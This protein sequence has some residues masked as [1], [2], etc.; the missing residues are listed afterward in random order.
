MEAVTKHQLGVGVWPIASS[1]GCETREPAARPKDPFGAWRQA[2]MAIVGPCLTG[3]RR[4]CQ[5]WLV[6]NGGNSVEYR[7]RL[8]AEASVVAGAVTLDVQLL[9]TGI[10]V[11]V[12]GTPLASLASVQS[13]P[14]NTGPRRGLAP[15][16]T[17]EPDETTRVGVLLLVSEAV[18]ERITQA[19]AEPERHA[20]VRPGQYVPT[21]VAEP[22][23]TWVRLTPGNPRSRVTRI[24][25]SSP[26]SE[27]SVSALYC[28]RCLAA[29]PGHTP[30]CPSG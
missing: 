15:R 23:T 6:S 10:P 14:P 9:G 20:V 28:L 19:L 29:L 11:E 25:A 26:D 5:S 16:G 27:V 2:A 7:T 30:N 21:S 24:L 8:V 22:T 12:T 4:T 18:R 1:R 17:I 3:R 13:D